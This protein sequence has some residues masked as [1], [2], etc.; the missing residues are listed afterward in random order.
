MPNIEFYPTV[1]TS[2]DETADTIRQMRDSGSFV[3]LRH[4]DEIMGIL[5]NKRIE[6][7]LQ[8]M[9]YP[10]PINIAQFHNEED[11]SPYSAWRI[12]YRERSFVLKK[13]KGQE[14]QSYRQWFSEAVCYAPRLCAADDE[15]LVMEYVSGCD[16]MHCTRDKLILALNSLIAMQ[17]GHWTAPSRNIPISR[18][19]RREFLDH[20]RLKAAYD[21]Y[22]QAFAS[23][24]STLCHDDLLPFNVLV[25]P[26]RAV[27][28]DWEAAGIL[29]YPTSL[30]RLI[31]H[32]EEKEGAFFYMKNADR[33]FAADYYYEHLAAPKGITRP[34]FDRAL[35]LCLFYEY[36]EWVYVGNKYGE[37]DNERFRKY[38]SMALDQ[39]AE[40]GY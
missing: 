22:L 27:F 20:P 13:A 39:A 2:E 38:Y 15:Y 14:L 30:A 32:A 16:L 9:G 3:P 24:P 21:A 1:P 10:A 28:I 23:M 31:A 36:C 17:D 35:S 18:L 34:E 11:G 4:L 19:N 8:G 6:T 7:I 5:S 33:A 29:P 40:L 26:E 25:T 12:D 37:T